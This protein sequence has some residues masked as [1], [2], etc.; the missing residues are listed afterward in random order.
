MENIEALRVASKIVD[1]LQR[2]LPTIPSIVIAEVVRGVSADFRRELGNASTLSDVRDRIARLQA[3]LKDVADGTLQEMLVRAE[4]ET[5][6]LV[7][8]RK[9][10][11]DVLG[12]RLEDDE[13]DA[14]IREMVAIAPL[15]SE[16]L[17]RII[18]WAAMFQVEPFVAKP[19]CG[20]CSNVLRFSI[21]THSLRCLACEAKQTRRGDVISND[22][23]SCFECGSQMIRWEKSFRCN[24]C[25]VTTGIS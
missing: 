24:N 2:R 17:R 23:P 8:L 5:A 4:I 7:L 10:K 16:A 15:G 18:L 22:A 20:T 13:I 25:G 14:Q 21:E 6:L 9:F 3:M 11:A 1:E 19:E 12:H